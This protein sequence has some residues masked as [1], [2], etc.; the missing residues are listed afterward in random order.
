MLKTISKEQ[1]T[2]LMI[3]ITEVLG[4]SLILPF[5]P[6]FALDL[7]ASMFQIGM[8]AASFSFFQFFSSPI[9]GKLSDRFGRKPLLLLSQCSTL[10]G[11]LILGFANTL[12]LIALSRIIDGLFGSNFVI[13]EAYLAD[14]SKKEER[15]KA[16]ALSGIAFG[17]GFLIGPIIGG[18]LSFLGMKY[19]AFFAALISV[20]SIIL[21]QLTL[22][23]T[24][25][26]KT[27]QPLSLKD[28]K[29]IDT[30]QL[31]NFFTSSVLS[32][33]MSAFFFFIF[34]NVF[35]ISV[36]ALYVQNKFSLRAYDVG[37]VLAYVGVLAV[38]LR[39]V[40]MPTCL[41]FISERRLIGVAFI[42]YLSAIIWMALSS[43]YPLFIVG[44]TF[45]ILGTG[46]L[47]PLI[48]TLLSVNV[49]P[50]EQGALLGLTNSFTSISQIVGPSVGGFLLNYI[51]PQSVLFTVFFIA[52]ISL[53]FFLLDVGKKRVYEVLAVRS[54]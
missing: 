40:I 8:I 47:R 36:F 38:L 13:A 2:I 24:I 27:S 5:L 41:R 18:L 16:F 39:V 10:L 48:Q 35:F 52:L 28:V 44:L 46:L 26:S 32:K 3:M 22:K 14:I 45:Y 21:T 33:K 37:F 4:F 9:L 17:V 51:N 30:V 53:T 11:F 23:E 25:T 7:G 31:K 29:F 15:S 49:S 19:L 34:S 42:F 50:T 12:W 6:F 43:S 1:F 20:F 54:I